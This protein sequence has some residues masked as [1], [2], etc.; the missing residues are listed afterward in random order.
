MQKYLPLLPLL[1]LLLVTI[2]A[3]GIYEDHAEAWTTVTA[4]SGA[5]VNVS[6][7]L[8]STLC[9]YDGLGYYDTVMVR[10]G[11]GN[12]PCSTF[13]YGEDVEFDLVDL[14]IERMTN[15]KDHELTI[16]YSR[17]NTNECFTY[18]SSS[19]RNNRVRLHLHRGAWWNDEEGNEDGTADRVKI[20]PLKYTWVSQYYIP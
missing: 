10:F 11:D 17:E 8:R 5:V 4:K 18:A 19:I 14:I 20:T 7:S 13:R 12:L 3:A 16:S 9:T 2:A 1:L 15:H 6:I